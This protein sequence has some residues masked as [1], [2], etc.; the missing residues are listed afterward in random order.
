[1]RKKSR[2]GTQTGKEQP[3]S[4]SRALRKFCLGKKILKFFYAD[5]GSV[6]NIPDPQHCLKIHK[7]FDADPGSGTF[8]TLDPGSGMEKIRTVNCNTV[9][10][11]MRLPEEGGGVCARMRGRSLLWRTGLLPPGSDCRSASRSSSV[12]STQCRLSNTGRRRP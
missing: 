5:L 11:V 7:F 10:K 6:I 1:M 3:G 12:G 2:S 9:K 4:F 8:V